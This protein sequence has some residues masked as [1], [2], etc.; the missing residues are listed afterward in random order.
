[1]TGCRYKRLAPVPLVGR[2]SAVYPRSFAKVESMDKRHIEISDAEADDWR[3]IAEFN[4]ALAEESE[5]KT[6]D[7]AILESGVRRLLEDTARGR[8]FLARHDGRVVGQTLITYEW[9]DWRDGWIWWIQSV[10]VDPGYRRQGVFRTLYRHIEALARND[11]DVVAIRLYVERENGR[12]QDTYR[13]LGMA[14]TGY[15]VMESEFEDINE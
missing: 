10:Y 3:V 5:D 15:R 7:R 2:P 11:K 1:M 4:A 14:H 8:Y 6:L 12:A 13:S 9:S